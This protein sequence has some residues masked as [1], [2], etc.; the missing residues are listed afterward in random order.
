MKL[1]ILLLMTS[2]FAMHANDSYG[3][4]TKLSLDFKEMKVSDVIE[5][6]ETE[7]DFRFVYNVKSLDLERRVSITVKNE[8]IETVL[9][10]IFKN[11]NTDY[12]INGTLIV[13]KPKKVSMGYQLDS[14]KN[15]NPIVI[16]GKVSDENGNPLVGASVTVKATGV[17]VITDANGF[18]SL[19]AEENSIL[20][21]SFIGFKTME[22]AVNGRAN[23]NVILKEDIASLQEVTVNAGYYTVKE[24]ERTGSIAKITSKDLETQP[25][26]NIL[27]TMQGRMAG[28]N[29]VQET[30]IAGGGFKINI[31]GVNSLREDANSP[32]YIIDGIPYSTD[33]ISDLQTSTST[34]GNGNPLASI[35][36]NDIESIEVLKDADATA[37]YG[38]RGANGVVL[39]TTKKG[40][41][42]KTSVTITTS[43]AVGSVTKMMDLMNTEQYL[44]M[45]R[46]A[47]VNDGITTYPANAYD[48][49]G[50][51][52]QNRYTD[53]Q[54][55]L[56][57]GTSEVNTLQAN[58][59]GGNQQ[60]SFLV[61]GNYRT[62]SS[63]FPG[64]FLYKRG[65][66]RLN[67]NHRSDDNKFSIQFSGSYMVQNNDL[68]W[69]DYV[70]LSR[71][72]A[73]NAP[74][75]YDA[76][77]NLNWENNT[78]VNPLSNNVRKCL[79]FTT[80]LIANTVMSY[81]LAN[82]LVLKSSF[83][84][85]DLSNEDSRSTPSTT[86]N[87]SFNLSSQYSS[88]YVNNLRRR[89]WIMEPQLS[90]KKEF[91]NATVDVL[92]GATFQNQTSK[93]QL[94][95]ATGFSSNSLLYD[96]AA[97]S[98]VLIRNNEEIDYKYQ[99]FFGR[100]NYTYAKKYILNLTARRDGS[101][102]FASGNQ[103]ATFGAIGAAW[104]F[105][106]EE[107]L[108]PI[109]RFLSFG[110]LRV[111]YG[112]TGS[113]QIGDYQYLDTYSSSGIS[114]GG[115]IGLQPS[116]LYNT[117]F[118]WESNKKLEVALELGFLNDRILFS[119]ATYRNRS[120]NQLVGLPLPGTTGFPSIQT[121][122][123]AT[124]ENKGVEFTLRTE[125]IKSTNF[126]WISNFNITKAG[127]K[128]LSFP[129]LENSAYRNQYVIGQPTTIQKLF[130]FTGVDPQTGLYQFTDFNGDGVISYEY[131]RQVVKDFNPDF[132]GGLQNVFTYKGFQ[133]DFL[134]QFVKQQN[135]NFA[136]TQKFAGHFIN[137]PVAYLNSWQ[138]AG[139]NAPYQ[140]FATNAN[141]QAT[142]RSD[143][144]GLSSGAVNDASFIRLK[145]ISVAYTLPKS[146]LPNV[147]CRLALEGQNVLTFT[148]Y[149][150]A[151]PEFVQGGLLPPLKMYSINL[152][153]TF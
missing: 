123:N 15:A 24:K 88:I 101:S 107:F 140:L 120:S 134:F 4:K 61:S 80:D 59:T 109:E 127:N 55:V 147:S 50:T 42:G 150:G 68:P 139:D 64:D 81:K 89:S 130:Q 53:W 97:A 103:F 31:R 82:N 73:P 26:P 71:Q 34:I 108:K 118:G 87:P 3:Q 1:T 145:N 10:A 44:T 18:F 21:F 39:I 74:A 119:T 12:K 151:D 126:S 7:T 57:G 33:A 121:N 136:N 102:R 152:Q 76:N 115:I 141:S 98:Q 90:W 20:I 78:W 11:T 125:N 116:R 46:K 93:K 129:G 113:D 128:L 100:A 60:T 32:L 95:Y 94:A 153:L 8:K 43:T 138:E 104:L 85:S 110:K 86:Y 35:N 29:I 47:F 19:A 40:K 25:V 49:N 112:T 56:I 37:I 132:Y 135:F 51:W 9:K 92:L 148:K 45:R 58:I 14:M 23:I 142:Q 114:Y 17:G 122:L 27:A 30:G 54:K 28:V 36:P 106:K 83:G 48:V 99:A 62:E 143:F 77:G 70:S 65:G 69:I 84:V 6:I 133:L 75:L 91:G 96:L 16:N 79:T 146:V 63:V 149:Q 72:L 111:S 137:Q 13:L 66:A 105:H 41:T 131:D 22:E 144:F 52:D 2:L 67:F 124:V 5:K 117:N 38:S